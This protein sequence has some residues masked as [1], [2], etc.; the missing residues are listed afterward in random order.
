MRAFRL[1][2]VVDLSVASGRI[3]AERNTGLVEVSAPALIRI[4]PLIFR[5]NPSLTT[6]DFPLLEEASGITLPRNA[7]LTTLNLP[8]LAT[9]TSSLNLDSA[10]ALSTLNLPSLT[11]LSG[12]SI[13]RADNLETLDGFSSVTSGMQ[14]LNIQSNASLRDYDGLLN[15]GD[16]LTADPIFFDV[17]IDNPLV[18]RDDAEAF[19]D[20]LEAKF[21]GDMATFRNSISGPTCPSPPDGP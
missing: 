12:L 11:S 8:S 10:E 9:I 4:R 7:A 2:S 21:P 18:C 20:A 6:L 19:R 1:P 3:L 14:G 16:A 15:V 5:D 17:R 13:V